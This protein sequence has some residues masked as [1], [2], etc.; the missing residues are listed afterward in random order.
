MVT[1]KK[2]KPLN[3][4]EFEKEK[5]ELI[6]LRIQNKFYD[7]SDV[8]EEVASKIIRKELSPNQSTS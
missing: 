3:E 8:L 4:M 6:R 1:L 2:E 7:R 5:L